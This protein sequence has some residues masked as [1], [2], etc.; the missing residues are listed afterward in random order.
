MKVWNYIQTVLVVR[1]EALVFT[2]RVNGHMSFGQILG[3][4]RL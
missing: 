3:W 4:K 2:F 1:V